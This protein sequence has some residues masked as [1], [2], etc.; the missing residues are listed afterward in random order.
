MNINVRVQPRSNR[1]AIE[2]S[3]GDIVKVRVTAPP[4]RGKA[5]DA[6]IRLIADR[7]GV[8]RSAVRIVRGHTSRNKVVR[9]EGLDRHKAFKRIQA[10]G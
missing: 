8:A 9:V 10:S 4:E 5:N 2:V 1:N 7:F 6:A 3:G